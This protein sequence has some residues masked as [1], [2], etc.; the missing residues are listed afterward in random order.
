MSV[1]ELKKDGIKVNL[2]EVAD[3]EEL[4]P[5]LDGIPVSTW[6]WWLGWEVIYGSSDWHYSD[7]TYQ[8][9]KG[10]GF[11]PADFSPKNPPL[12]RMHNGDILMHK[13]DVAEKD[14]NGRRIAE[15]PNFRVTYY[16]VAD[17]VV[18]ML[19]KKDVE[20]E[21]KPYL[22]KYMKDFMNQK[23]I[24]KI[25]EDKQMPPKFHITSISQKDG[26]YHLAYCPTLY[27]EEELKR[28]NYNG[29]KRSN[30]DLWH[31]IVYDSEWPNF[32]N[33]GLA[34][35]LNKESSP[36]KPATNQFQKTFDDV[37]KIR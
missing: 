2:M 14:E 37:T 30:P 29:R 8:I 19:M 26:N 28:P 9:G 1:A 27:D 16:L 21:V 12:I 36:S 35:F 17:D 5:N 22:L 6:N 18:Y 31:F 20:D 7:K 33:T 25:T 32:E 3:K 10:G 23:G 15:H 13:I 34:K 24:K 11:K 4:L